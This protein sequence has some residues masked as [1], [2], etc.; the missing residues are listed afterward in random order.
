[1][2]HPVSY[3]III[4]SFVLETVLIR[5]ASF[6]TYALT[7]HGFYIGGIAFFY[8]YMIIYSGDRFWSRLQKFRW[9]F[10]LMAIAFFTIRFL[11]YDLNAP[12]YLKA[13][14]S[15]V[16][17]FAVFGFTSKHLNKPS[18]TLAYL[19]EGAYPIYII[20][21]VFLYLGS[22]LIIPLTLA[23]FLKFIL[24]ILFTMLGCIL[25][26]EFLLKRVKILRPLFGLKI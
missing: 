21:M 3:L 22:Y 6:E 19:S 1:M 20:H 9:I 17:I 15:C 11:A 8:G 5:P 24:I 23:P 10:I 16:W 7:M 25:C 12:N 2:S 18:K 26:Y 4:G 13:I 14:E